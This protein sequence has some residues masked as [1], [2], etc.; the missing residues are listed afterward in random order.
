[1]IQRRSLSDWIVDA[2]LIL[3]ALIIGCVVLLDSWPEHAP[4]M[5]WVDVLVGLPMLIAL[6]RRRRI[7][8]ELGIAS[9]LLATFSALAAGPALIGAFNAAVH[10]SRRGL[11]AVAVASVGSVAVF[12]ALYPPGDGYLLNL[13][14]GALL[15]AVVFAWGLVVR[16]R[17]EQVEALHERAVADARA[18]ERRRIAREMHDVLAHRLSLLALHAG[19][20]EYRGD[21]A[22]GVIRE[23]ARAALEDLRDV[24][25]LLRDGGP[26][27][28]PEPPQP[29][30][31]D[32]AMLIE[33]SRAA[34][35]RVRADVSAPGVPEALGR[36][37]YRIVQEGL[38]NARKH[39]AGAAVDVLVTGG[40][41]SCASS[42]AADGRWAW[43]RPR[44]P[45]RAAGSSASR[46]AS[47]WPAAPSTP[48]GRGRVPTGTSCSTR[49][50]RGPR[51]D[52]RRRPAGPLGPADAPRRG[53]D[54]HVVGE[55]ADGR[56]VLAAVDR[57]RPDVVLMDIRMPVVDGIDAPPACCARSRARRRC[58]S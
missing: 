52:R 11:I 39:A 9:A 37:A 2:T 47:R 20:L 51:P 16:S 31:A 10:S 45:A 55:A 19:A 4:A 58:S 50:C 27:E 34:G 54:G 24:I 57:H 25:G 53:G 48:G 30:L 5:K 29:T 43:R 32:L 26:A 46:S 56:E 22:A 6:G 1:M 15:T 14:I 12:P 21:E 13:F 3:A 44:C 17:R 38:T 35:M 23:N 42:C 41:T 33:E 18:A 28:T 49:G 40:G 36:T 8:T 7:P